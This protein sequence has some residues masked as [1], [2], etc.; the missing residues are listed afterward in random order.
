MKEKSRE[1]KESEKAP[2][3]TRKEK[4]KLRKEKKNSG[5]VLGASHWIWGQT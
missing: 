2:Q 1:L 5:L 3:M 4:R